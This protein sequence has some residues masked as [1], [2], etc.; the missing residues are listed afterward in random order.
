MNKN[1]RLI[2]W[3]ASTRPRSDDEDQIRREE[4]RMGISGATG[5]DTTGAATTTDAN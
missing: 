2:H 1:D 3:R 5:G 4:V